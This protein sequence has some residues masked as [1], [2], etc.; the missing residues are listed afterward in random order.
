VAT[1]ST[2]GG[3][4][5]GDWSAP[6]RITVTSPAGATRDY[7]V[8]TRVMRSPVLPGLYADPNIVR[9]G[10]TYYI[11][12]T[13]D[14]FD[15]WSGTTF[16]VWSSTDLAT[17]TKHGIILDLADVSWAHTNAWAPTAAYANGKYYFY[18]C[19]AGNIGVAT[20]DSPTG[21]FTDSGKPLVNRADYGNA[22]Q[23]DP[24]VFTDDDGQSYLYWGNTTAHVA[25][26]NADMASLGE[27]RTIPGLTDFREGLFMNKRNG[28]YYLSYSIDDTGSENY[29]VG[30]ATATSPWGPFTARGVILAKDRSLGILGTGHSSIIQV[31][32]TD[33]WYIAY[34][35]FAIP[36][37]NATHRETTID[38]L[39]FGA[40]GLIQP[41]RPTLESIDPLTYTGVLPTASLP[42]SGWLGANATLTFSGG[43][44]NSEIQYALTPG[45][46]VT[47]TGPVALP[48]GSYPVS[49]RARGANLI[50]SAPVDVRVQVDVEA[51]TIG[52]Q[53]AT[54]GR[55]STV[56]LIAQD[57]ASGVAAIAYRVDGGGWQD[58]RAPFTVDGVHDVEFRAT[59][60]AGN[61]SAAQRITVPLV[62]DRT[63][64]TV[65]A[66]TRPGRPTGSNGWYVSA[67][68]VVVTASDP[69]GV[70][71]TEYRIDGGSWR[72]YTGPIPTHDGVSTV[73]FRATDAW[74]NQSPVGSLT[75]KR[76]T[77]PPTAS[78]KVTTTKRSA[79][80]RLSAT[81][82]VSG[83]Q[84]IQY[85]VDG[86]R[87]WRTYR[88]PVTV[89]KKGVHTVLYRAVDQ[90]GNA[91]YP[92]ILLLWIR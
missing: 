15:G 90:A 60:R 55:A 1:G 32:G 38:R 37:G 84:L 16:T 23:I 9:F 50:L 76:D 52:A 81:D 26:L 2:V 89:S 73:Q 27:Q 72:T 41:V 79:T 25:K 10:D 88:G 48:A 6:R 83:V 39:S 62:P 22:Q 77:A 12:A 28:I 44:G 70:T 19:A 54:A 17:W 67:V 64:P 45:A 34:H 69:A 80:V 3:A 33:D 14:G 42:T 68:S 4:Q 40:D 78:A 91:S 46:W 51:P 63:G 13:T 18:F 65:T 56:T 29:R 36:G 87:T 92:R 20:A 21:P 47:Y 71:L 74:G 85:R 7:T 8:T 75:V 61:T 30:Y 53:V 58:Y 82:K 66:D 57:T 59:D 86:D 43:T 5:A 24:A 11:Y 49:Y 35:R 31:P